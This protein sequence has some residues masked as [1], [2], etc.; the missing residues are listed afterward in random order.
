MVENKIPINILKGNVQVVFSLQNQ[1]LIAGEARV[2]LSYIV[3]RCGEADETLLNHNTAQCI[4]NKKRAVAQSF[5]FR[6]ISGKRT[7]S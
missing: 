4:I 2:K 3:W 1:L 5:R 7:P 6:H